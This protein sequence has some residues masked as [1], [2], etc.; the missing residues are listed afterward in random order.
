MTIQEALNI[1]IKAAEAGQ[2]KG[3]YSFQ[4]ASLILEAIKLITM[5]PKEP[6]PEKEPE[7]PNI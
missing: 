7:T 2:A 4:D 3:A 5:P 6:E 1:L